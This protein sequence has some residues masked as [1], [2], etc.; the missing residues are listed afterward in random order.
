MPYAHEFLCKEEFLG[1]LPLSVWP[2]WKKQAGY[3]E[4]CQAKG[5]GPP[6]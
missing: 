5:L 3:L 2:Q 6:F 4:R 1:L